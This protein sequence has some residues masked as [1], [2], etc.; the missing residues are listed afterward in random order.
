MEII[1]PGKLPTREAIDINLSSLWRYE[2]VLSPTSEEQRITLGEGWTPFIEAG[3]YRGI[4]LCFKDETK[5]PSGSFKDRGMAVAISKAKEYGV[6]EI[7]LPSAGNAGV[8]AAAYGREAGV[9]CHVYLPGRIPHA[10]VKETENYG[11]DVRLAG[12]TL[13]ES[14]LRMQEEK[15]AAWFDLSTLR[16]P[17]R[18]EGKKTLGYE[19]AEQLGWHF[20]DVVIYPTGGGTGLI[21]MWKA[22]NEM[23]RLHWVEDELPR[24]VV[25][26]SSECAPVVKA[27]V[28]GRDRCQPWKKGH[29]A[30]LGLNSPDPIGGSWMLKVLRESRGTA[31]IV[32]EALIQSALDEVAQASGTN[33]SPEVGV[34]WLGF[35]QL[36]GSGW[37]RPGQKVVIPVTGSGERYG[38]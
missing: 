19:I 25:V 10:F 6:K 2:C 1:W 12:N 34:A 32:K 29:T 31:V 18:V 28:E 27:F 4:S 26:Q 15:E 20:P 38:L 5:N 21:G 16:E 8:A 23:R 30:A 37:I 13:A 22:F 24:M 9:V 3:D 7:C 17:F 35:Q 11:A 14:A 36:T 33:P